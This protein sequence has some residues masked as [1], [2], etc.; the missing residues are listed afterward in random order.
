MHGIEDLFDRG[1]LIRPSHQKP[2]LV[3]LVRALAHVGGVNG[4]DENETTRQLIDLIGQPEHL[5]FVL[6]DGLGAST[7]RKLPPDSFIRRHLAMEMLT[8]SPSTTACALT[9]VAT[10]DYPGRHGVTGWFTH[11]PDHNLTMTALPFVERF[12][13]QPL[14][15]RGIV[16]TDVLPL[17][18]FQGRMTRDSLT[19]LPYV[20]THTV[21]ATYSRGDTP[22]HGYASYHHAVDL[23]I[24]HIAAATRPTYTHLYLPE[25]DTKC[26][27]VGVDHPDVVSLVMQI[28]VEMARLA[29]AIEGRG[30]LVISADHGLIDVPVGDQI[31]LMSDDPLLAMLQAPPSGDARMPLF[32]VKP[33]RRDEFA[34]AFRRRFADRFLLLDI[35]T[36][37]ELRLFSPAG[38]MSPHARRRFGD[39]AAIAFRPA[40]LAFHPPNKPLGHLYTALHAG[41]S[42][43]E[44]EVPLCI[45]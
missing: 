5:V 7:V 39:F 20:I 31:L 13:N 2:N 45:A 17:P 8:I 41:L 9:S 26:H 1:V 23:I 44:M 22:A 24:S 29:T 21:Y 19:L 3:H 35:E 42:P 14:A 34:D 4:F 10:A 18:A 12:T 11:L 28:D 15:E 40:S 38:P 16:P 25:V 27:H 43:Q 36:I 32:H 33:D 6:L 37:E 30:R